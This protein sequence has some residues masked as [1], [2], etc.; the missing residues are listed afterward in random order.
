MI[1]RVL[2]GGLGGLSAVAC[3]L[4]CLVPI[5]LTAGVIGG[6]GWAVVGR[7]LPGATVA[8]I[9]LTGAA[10]WWASR[11]RRHAPGCAGAACSCNE[12]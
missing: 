6:A 4:C 10:W 5:L 3:A 7:V 2:R 8:L 11:S 9:A 12:A 1:R